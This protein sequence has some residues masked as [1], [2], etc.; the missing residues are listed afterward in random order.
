[1]SDQFTRLLTFID[2]IK[3]ATNDNMTPWETGSLHY[4][5]T[6]SWGTSSSSSSSTTVLQP[7]EQ[8]STHST[9]SSTADN[10][11]HSKKMTIIIAVVAAVAA[12]ILLFAFICLL[13]CCFRRRRARKTATRQNQ[14]ENVGFLNRGWQKVAGEEKLGDEDFG[15][16][17]YNARDK[18]IHQDAPVYSG[19]DMAYEPFRPHAGSAA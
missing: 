6:P 15:N 10:N 7:L 9:S 5:T 4:F 13:R 19:K 1:M 2:N 14:P 18:L 16:M 8:D 12:L 11:K 17:P 3:R